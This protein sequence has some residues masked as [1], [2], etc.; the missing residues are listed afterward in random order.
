M[1]DLILVLDA[2]DQLNL[3]VDES[4]ELVLE[5]SYPY[6]S[7][8]DKFPGPYEVTPFFYDDQILQTENKVMMHDLVVREIPVTETTN[9]YG[10]RTVV[11]G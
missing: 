9:P 8:H 4:D 10:G 3:S 2:D 1:D 7:Y 11:I 6:G 5:D